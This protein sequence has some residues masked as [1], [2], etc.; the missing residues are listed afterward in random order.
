MEHAGVSDPPMKVSRILLHPAK[1]GVFSVFGLGVGRHRQQSR[2]LV[3]DEN[4]FVFVEPRQVESRV[5]QCRTGGVEIDRARRWDLGGRV[6]SGDPVHEH[7]PTFDGVANP[8]PRQVG[9]RITKRSI[10]AA[11]LWAGH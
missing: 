7:L 11:G 1:N 5:R 6:P 3:D 4:V 10:E 8:R 9:A 2:W